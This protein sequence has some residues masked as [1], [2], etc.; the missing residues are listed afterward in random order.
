MRKKQICLA[1]RTIFHQRH[2]KLPFETVKPLPPSWTT[3]RR[4][5]HSLKRCS[6][7]E[8]RHVVLPEHPFKF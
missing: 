1:S 8:P 6:M 3:W 2:D 4:R 5:T 7:F